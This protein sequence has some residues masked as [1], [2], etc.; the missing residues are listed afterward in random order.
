MSII[1]RDSVIH[2]KGA[3]TTEYIPEY[4]TICKLK[5]E[6][7]IT[8]QS[9]LNPD[10]GELYYHCHWYPDGTI[11]LVGEPHCF[12]NH[13]C[14]PNVIYYT[15]N[16]ISYLISVKEIQANEE[17]TLDYSQLNYGGQVFHCKCGSKN[18]RGDHRCGFKYMPKEQQVR[19][20]LVLDPFIVQIHSDSI[21]ELLEDNLLLRD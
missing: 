18:C 7:Q 3:F 15:I 12:L 16:K 21:Q 11:V 4:S 9:P 10:R 19:Q 8:E 5:I 6:R 1:V 14:E 13:S 17:L 20:L 2:G